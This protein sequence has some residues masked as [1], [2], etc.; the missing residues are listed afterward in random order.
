MARVQHMVVLQMK[1]GQEAQVAPLFAALEK[2]RQTL[3]GIVHFSGGPYRSSEGAN[4]G[5]TQGFLMTF[6]DPAARDRYLMHPDHEAVKQRFLPF[7]AGVVAFDY[8]E[9]SEGQTA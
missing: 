1:P 4:Q 3:P 8:E 2:L 7:V 9:G 6:T 5:Y